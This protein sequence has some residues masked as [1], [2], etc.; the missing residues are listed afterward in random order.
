MVFDDETFFGQ[1]RI[2]LL[3]WRLEQAGVKRL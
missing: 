2:D 3:E 1:D